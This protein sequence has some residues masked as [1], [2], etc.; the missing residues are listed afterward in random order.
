MAPFPLALVYPALALLMVTTVSNITGAFARSFV[1]CDAPHDED[2]AAL[3]SGSAFCGDRL[4]VIG[5]GARMSSF[6]AG[7][8][9]L[10]KCFSM[11]LCAA[12]A[13][14]RGRR[15]M[16]LFNACAIVMSSICFV[17][18]SR[19]LSP[20]F[21]IIG[22]GVLGLSGVDFVQDVVASDVAMSSGSE[23]T[24]VFR[25]KETLKNLAQVVGL[26]S[27]AFLGS[28]QVRDYTGIW[29]GVLAIAAALLFI[30][31]AKFPETRN[32]VTGSSHAGT[33]SISSVVRKELGAYRKVVESK[34]RAIWYIIE[35][36]CFGTFVAFIP[37]IGAL[38]MAYFGYTQ[39]EVATRC[40]PLLLLSGPFSAIVPS[41]CKKFGRSRAF[42][43]VVLSRQI[44][45]LLSP[46]IV[47]HWSGFWIWFFCHM[48]LCGEDAIRRTVEAKYI[49]EEFS[50]KFRALFMLSIFVASSA[51]NFGFSILFDATATSIIGKLK[52]VLFM[53]CGAH[54]CGIM[55]AT[56][57]RHLFYDMFAI[58]DKEDAEHELK[59]QG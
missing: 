40:L 54:I 21:Y 23:A 52:P 29:T 55:W 5:E 42:T 25:Q 7:V 28:L 57:N 27:G 10:C 8:S 26:V 20:T 56:I 30:V 18:A 16:M 44:V 32:N 45:F 4:F 19:F 48:L 59:K 53:M 47:F 58:M 6:A 35:A 13:D 46:I 34:P 51:A 3:F 50:V 38:L 14:I 24:H 49:G 37:I 33:N 43:I 17:C 15:N 11:L 39:A 9:S 12:L 22:S 2:P 36:C 41:A 1:T 31:L